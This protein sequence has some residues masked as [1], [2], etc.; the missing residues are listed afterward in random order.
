MHPAQHYKMFRSGATSS[1]HHGSQIW[2]AHKLA[3]YIVATRALSPRVVAVYF[4]VADLEVLLVSAHAPIEGSDWHG[5]FW[6]QLPS[7]E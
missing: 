7:S 3:S 6:S 5:E 2:L 1:G 4:N